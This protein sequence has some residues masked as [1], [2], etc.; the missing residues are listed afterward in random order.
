MRNGQRSEHMQA[1]RKILIAVGVTLGIIVPVGV[2]SKP[3]GGYRWPFS[4][5]GKNWQRSAKMRVSWLT[6]GVG[7]LEG[8]V[9]E[10]S[11]DKPTPLTPAQARL[12]CAALKPWQQNRVLSEEEA[13]RLFGQ[14]VEILSPRQKQEIEL[15]MGQPP[16][17]GGGNVDAEYTPGQRQ[18]IEAYRQIYNP[19]YAPQAQQGYYDL[20]ADLRGRYASRFTLRNNILLELGRKAQ[21]YK[22]EGRGQI[23]RSPSP[24]TRR[25]P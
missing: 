21:G 12:F 18:L 4:K 16:Q 24:K 17:F 5:E 11:H 13:T 22:A 20:P 10:T 9:P 6:L 7:A 8:S 1:F 2:L 3:S 23:A 25:K 15:L 14:L 19:F